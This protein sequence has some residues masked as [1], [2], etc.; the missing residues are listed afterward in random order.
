ML[1]TSGDV[2]HYLKG[3]I[4]MSSII[5]RSKS[6]KGWIQANFDRSQLAD[7]ASHGADAGWPGL[8]EG[9]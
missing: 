9:G 6:F 3:V 4:A 1:K 8:T 7:I 5:V 2:G